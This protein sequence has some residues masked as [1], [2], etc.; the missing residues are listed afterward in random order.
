M[1]ESAAP[2]FGP[3]VFDIADNEAAA[4]AA[5]F[6]LR[7]ALGGGATRARLV[8]LVAFVL[9][10][11]FAATLALAGRVTRRHGEEAVIAAA[12]VF[13]ANGA[14]SRWR[15]RR[16]RR[17]AISAIAAMRVAAPLRARVDPSGIEFMSTIPPRRWNFAECAEA[18][19]AGGILYLWPRD[20]APA[21]VPT[22]I[23]A[24]EEA[25]RLLAYIRA[26]IAG[27]RG[28]PLA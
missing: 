27:G 1:S 17:E 8:A 21:L 12:A 22:R 25:Q 3:Y 18:E 11:A 19:E 10:L 5:R 13:M 4:A 6:G 26:G 28:R 15:L 23:L 24:G 2:P 16:L 14:A 9:V 20:G 7:L